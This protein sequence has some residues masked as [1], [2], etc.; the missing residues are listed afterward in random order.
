MLNLETTKDGNAVFIYAH[1]SHAENWA[2]LA[3]EVDKTGSYFALIPSGASFE[4]Y[5]SHS[6]ETIKQILRKFLEN[7]ALDWF[8]KDELKSSSCFINGKKMSSCHEIF[9][10]K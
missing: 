2:K 9:K 4:I 10:K 3:I 5:S 8:Q 1:G 6:S 7:G